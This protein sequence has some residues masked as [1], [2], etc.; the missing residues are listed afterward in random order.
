MLHSCNLQLEVHSSDEP[1]EGVF[2][3]ISL[4]YDA[5]GIFQ[6]IA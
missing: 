4:P 1:V 5:M 3:G 2:R 6:Q